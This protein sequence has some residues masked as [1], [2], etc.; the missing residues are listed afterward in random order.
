MFTF[1]NTLC[2][3]AE[4]WGTKF[5]NMELPPD[6]CQITVSK[7]GQVAVMIN[8]ENEEDFTK[9]K[10]FNKKGEFEN[11]QILIAGGILRLPNQEKTEAE[12]TETWKEFKETF[13][14]GNDT[15]VRFHHGRIVR[16]GRYNLI[17]KLYSSFTEP[18]KEQSLSYALQ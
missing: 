8:G 1:F 12:L 13:L 3:S 10:L 14:K 4:F 6:N 17:I 15:I 9:V 16:E 7:V 18:E 2:W 5:L 11:L